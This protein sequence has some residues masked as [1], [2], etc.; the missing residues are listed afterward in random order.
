MRDRYHFFRNVKKCKFDLQDDYEF[1]YFKP[2][3]F[4]LKLH[5]G[6][7]RQSDLLYLFWFLFTLGK[8]HIFYIRDIKSGDLAHFSNILPAIFKYNFM[9]KKDVQIVNCWTY[10]KYR[11]MNFFPFA[12]SEIQEKFKY[13]TIW[14][15][16]KISNISSL[17]AIEKSGFT[18]M[19]DVEKRSILGIYFKINE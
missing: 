2:T 6:L 4:Q 9:N 14:I 12:L 3:L 17:N 16:S 8:Y 5:K 11:G 18:K 10:E 19:F 13:N 15:G 1:F 7:Y